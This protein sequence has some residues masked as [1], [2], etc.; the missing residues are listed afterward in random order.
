MK[1][2]LEKLVKTFWGKNWVM[3]PDIRTS[4]WWLLKIYTLLKANGCTSFVG[5]ESSKTEKVFDL[6]EEALVVTIHIM[7]SGVQ[8]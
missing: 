5:L 6:I 2:W 8:K 7:A 4:T 1:F 3:K